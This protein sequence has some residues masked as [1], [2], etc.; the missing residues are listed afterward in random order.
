MDGLFLLV[1]GSFWIRDWYT[2]RCGGYR[3]HIGGLERLFLCCEG[4]QDVPLVC[5]STVW[6][7]SGATG[8]FCL[9]LLKMQKRS[10]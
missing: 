6:Y 3:M 1:E 8:G 10:R 9:R 4:A 2:P 5:K 7:L